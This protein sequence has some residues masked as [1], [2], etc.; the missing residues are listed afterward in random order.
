LIV[1]L[2]GGFLAFVF[3]ASLINNGGSGSNNQSKEYPLSNAT[4]SEVNS[5]VGCKSNFSDDKKEDVFNATYK[6]HWMT[7]TG[8]VELAEATNASLNMDDFGTQDL[9]VYFADKNA[10]YNLTKGSKITIKFLM[11]RSGGCFLPFSGKN[12]VILK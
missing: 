2:A 3:V 1:K 12:A 4:Y 7:W 9:M 5:A 10:G 11:Q 8:V 6:D